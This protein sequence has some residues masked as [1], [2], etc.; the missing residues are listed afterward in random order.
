M[1]VTSHNGFPS[2]PIAESNTEGDHDENTFPDLEKNLEGSRISEIAGRN[3]E[4]SAASAGQISE[5]HSFL[6]ALQCEPTSHAVSVNTGQNDRSQVNSFP[7]KIN[8]L[9]ISP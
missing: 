7:S 6:S 8:L 5:H 9:G 1:T 2:R 3:S 4:R